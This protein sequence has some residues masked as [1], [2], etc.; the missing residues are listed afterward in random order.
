MRTIISFTALLISVGLM[1]LGNGALG[2]LD[3]LSG[4]YFSFSSFQIG[5]LGSA[6]FLGFIFGCIAAPKL[7]S[8]IGHVRA[9][10]AFA[11][12]G[13]IGTLLHTF[14]E[15]AYFW[16]IF[17][18]GS[19]M[20]IAGAFT[21]IEGWLNA[22]VTNENRGKVFGAY[23]AVDLGG[24][25]ISMLAIGVLEPGKMI[26]YN[27]IVLLFCL[28]LL[29]LTLTT[30][31]PPTLEGYPSLRPVWAIKISP[32][33]ACGILVAGISS[34]IF[35][36]LGPIFGND[37]G[38]SNPELGWFLFLSV[39]GGVIAQIPVGFASDRFDRRIV[40]ILLSV[41]AF[42]ICFF[43]SYIKEPTLV[44]LYFLAFMFGMFTF[45]IFSVSSAHA[46]DF[47]KGDDFINLASSH[48]FIYS[49]GAVSSP[50]LGSLV[51]EYFGSTALFSLIGIAHIF[52]IGFGIIRM[53]SR[54]SPNLRSPY[55]YM[56]RTSF[57][58]EKIRGRKVNKVE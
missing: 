36:M 2:P 16:M 39:L 22:K 38:L 35:R 51:M 56:A 3:A 54:P 47:V 21:V 55:A 10:A 57:V 24:S 50:F 14:T 6:H 44:Y 27:I 13:A 11:C 20:S 48:I 9:F 18:I 37:I 42:I 53:I 28:C 15:S 23:R 41:F 30:S 45:P 33:A 34:P 5:A 26:S 4:I 49:L 58:L 7:L 46:N 52:L 31:K 32:L 12:L 40:L 1:Q 17:R 25:M 19:G 43:F 29:P 8:V